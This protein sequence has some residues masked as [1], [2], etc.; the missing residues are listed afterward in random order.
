M[1][2]LSILFRDVHGDAGYCEWV[3]RREYKFVQ[4]FCRMLLRICCLS[5][6]GLVYR[7]IRS[8]VKDGHGR[9]GQ[10]DNVQC[11]MRPPRGRAAL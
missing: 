9:D 3:R 4:S 5:V 1:V 8:G 11:V 2:C 10:R 7:G 6:K